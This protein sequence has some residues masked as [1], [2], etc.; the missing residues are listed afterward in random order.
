MYRRRHFYLIAGHHAIADPQGR[1]LALPGE[2]PYA[3]HVRP[4]QERVS[5]VRN[6][7]QVERPARLLVEVGA[8]ELKELDLWH[9]ASVGR[10]PMKPT[11]VVRSLLPANFVV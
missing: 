1:C 6:P 3:G 8:V 7:L 5:A 11:R 2:H 9:G 10:D 4:R